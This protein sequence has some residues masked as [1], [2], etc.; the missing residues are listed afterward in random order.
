MLP[1][2]DLVVAP[3][4]CHLLSRRKISGKEKRRGKKKSNVRE[5]SAGREQGTL[6]SGPAES[7]RDIFPGGD[8]FGK[9]GGGE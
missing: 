6:V 4:P 9:M 7:E 3:C 2:T 8:W 5:G 1:Q